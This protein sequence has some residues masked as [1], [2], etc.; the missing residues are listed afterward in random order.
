[1]HRHV[2]NAVHLCV[3]HD[4][5]KTHYFSLHNSPVLCNRIAFCLLWHKWIFVYTQ[6]KVHTDFVIQCMTHAMLVR[7]CPVPRC[8]FTRPKHI[9]THIS[10]PERTNN[11]HELKSEAT[12]ILSPIRCLLLA[13][14][15]GRVIDERRPDL[16]H[17]P[18][19]LCSCPSSRLGWGWPHADCFATLVFACYEC[20]Y[21]P[22]D[23]F[24]KS[25]FSYSFVTLSRSISFSELFFCTPFSA[26]CSFRKAE[27][28]FQSQGTPCGICSIKI[29]LANVFIQALCLSFVSQPPL[30]R[31]NS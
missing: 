25:S 21:L 17:T 5:H 12:L 14:K 1:M 13:N 24:K 4:C 18:S 8:F 28:R 3:M 30:L 15:N 10:G 9:Q 23:A 16:S 20:G 2:S 19:R 7:H 29:V 6:Y 11:F 22:S 27:T 31:I 26:C